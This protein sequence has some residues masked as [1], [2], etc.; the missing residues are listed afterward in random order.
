MDRILVPLVRVLESCVRM[1]RKQNDNEFRTRKRTNVVSRHPHLPYFKLKDSK[2]WW[3]SNDDGTF[4]LNQVVDWEKKSFG[5]GFCLWPLKVWMVTTWS[6]SL[7]IWTIIICRRQQ[8]R[9]S[10][11]GNGV[12]LRAKKVSLR[13]YHPVH[14]SLKWICLTT[15]GWEPLVWIISIS[16][17]FR[18]IRW[19]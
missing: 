14:T 5:M 1:N 6:R 2:V 10:P 19:T 17:L 16:Y 11:Q 7:R 4:T 18:C 8:M 9:R 12:E 13:D 15:K 3:T